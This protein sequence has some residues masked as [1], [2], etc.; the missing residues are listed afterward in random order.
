MNPQLIDQLK[1]LGM[2]LGINGLPY[3]F[4][5]HPNFVHLTLGLFIIAIAFDFAGSLFPLE[6][7]VLKFFSMPVS[8]SN[9]FDVAWYNAVAASVI[10]FFTVAAGFFEMLLANPPVD[11]KSDWGLGAGTTMLL[12]G[13]GG[14]LLLTF[15][16][17][18]TIWRGYQRFRW[19]K[20]HPQQVQWSYLLVGVFILG[21]MF[22][23]GTL[24]AQLGAEFGVH[25]T[26][27][28]LIQQGKNP[29]QVLQP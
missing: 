9:F 12:H 2:E 14:V 25:G 17:A 18:M 1:Q 23:H 16:V 22:V 8:R 15:I 27:A 19:R 3:R 7:S 24:G 4:P 26:A 11:V 5:L 29:N 28:G 20:N 10:T 13:V 6:R 21:Y